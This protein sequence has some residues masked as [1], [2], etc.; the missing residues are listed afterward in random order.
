VAALRRN[1]EPEQDCFFEETNI[2]RR[3]RSQE[4]PGKKLALRP[5]TG[6]GLAHK[7]LSPGSPC[8]RKVKSKYL[9]P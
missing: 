8:Q 7:R 4:D 2:Q 6:Y 5:G 9:Y 1:K 3:L